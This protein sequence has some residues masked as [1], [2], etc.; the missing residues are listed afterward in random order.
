M[1]PCVRPILLCWHQGSRVRTGGWNAGL[2]ATIACDNRREKSSTSQPLSRFL[3]IHW[4]SM[5]NCHRFAPPAG[6][7][8]DRL[9]MI[10]EAGETALGGAP[11][12][13]GDASEPA[14]GQ[15]GDLT[16]AHVPLPHSYVAANWPVLRAAVSASGSDIAVA[17]RHGLAV[18]HRA[19]ERW[20]G[21]RR[22]G[23]RSGGETGWAGGAAGLG[24]A[25]CGSP[26][27]GLGTSWHWKR[28]WPCMG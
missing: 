2:L 26:W 5:A 27:R 6:Q 1:R 4:A 3:L 10:R 16:V 13:S 22:L 12:A 7:A 25:G 18:L 20:G 8:H 15:M 24:A 11:W 23:A 21:G 17:G 9:L 14:V 19:T 28:G